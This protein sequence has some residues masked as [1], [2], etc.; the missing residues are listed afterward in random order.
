LPGRVNDVAALSGSAT[1]QNTVSWVAMLLPELERS[2]VY[3]YLRE[4]TIH[5]EVNQSQFPIPRIDIVIC[6]SDVQA[7][8]A[9][10]G[11]SFVGNAGHWDLDRTDYSENGIFFG[12]ALRATGEFDGW[13]T[14][15][16]STRRMTMEQVRDG[17]A[18][19]MLISENIQAGPPDSPTGA[20]EE[21]RSWLLSPT[22]HGD[23]F[24]WANLP[25]QQAR[26]NQ[27]KDEPPQYDAVF[28]RPSSNHADGV[29]V[30]YCDAHVEFLRDSIDYRVY[31]QLM[32]SQGRKAKIPPNGTLPHADLRTYLLNAKDY[33]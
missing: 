32:T 26:I 14:V 31:Q 9:I 4:G 2:D 25:N 17:V 10:P 3:D 20:I 1:A 29:N 5:A 12:T 22:E 27:Y 7:S 6:P 8:G 13:L 28:C 18:T 16:D 30:A 11:L 23:G 21:P 33:Q 19:T 24:A 15:P